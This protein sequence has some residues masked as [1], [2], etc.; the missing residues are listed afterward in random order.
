MCK[1]LDWLNRPR[2]FDLL[3]FPPEVWLVTLSCATALFVKGADLRVV[4][5]R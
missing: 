2:K 5:V 1:M 4:V 3:K